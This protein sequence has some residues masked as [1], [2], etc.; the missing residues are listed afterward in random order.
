MID[1]SKQKNRIPSELITD[2]EGV[3]SWSLP[4]VGEK[5][6]VVTSPKKKPKPTKGE[7]VEDYDQ[8]APGPITAEQLKEITEQAHKEGYEAGYREGL[9]KGM[10]DGNAQGLKQGKEKAYKENHA[11]LTDEITRLKNIADALH[12]PMQQQ[13]VKL[14]NVILDMAYHFA[15]ELIQAEIEQ[16]PDKLA[17][18]INSVLTALPI[19][20]KNIS[21]SLNQKDADLIESHIPVSQRTWSVK[22]NPTLR[23]GGCLIDTQESFIDYSVEKRL[24]SYLKEIQ[25]HGEVQQDEVG[26]VH[27]Y[28]VDIESMEERQ[29][30]EV[31]KEADLEKKLQDESSETLAPV[32]EK[33][34]AEN[35]EPLESVPIDPLEEPS[36]DHSAVAADK[37]NEQPNE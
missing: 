21:V 33:A 23:S 4:S 36:I 10:K 1:P 9:N 25:S 8:S 30:E 22:L 35:S 6:H 13:D 20:A 34:K 12:D 37:N 7:I 15:Q 18:L 5:K 26:S 24:E 14:E 3:Q 27:D 29:D 28:L 19:G 2:V 32:M 16:K 31:L 11:Q 17:S